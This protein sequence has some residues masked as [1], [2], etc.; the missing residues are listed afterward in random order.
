MLRALPALLPGGGFVYFEGTTE[1]SFAAWLQANA[2]SAP[3][4]IAYGTIW[5]R[6]DDFHVPLHPVL[7]EEAAVLIDQ[8]GIALPSIHVHAHDGTKVLLEWHDAFVNDPMYVASQ[9]PRERVDAFASLMRVGPV[10]RADNAI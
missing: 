5:P 1:A 6:P 4:K 10:S 8:Q 3:L 9:I 7:L 2:V